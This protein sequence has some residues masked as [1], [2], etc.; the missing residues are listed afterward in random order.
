MQIATIEEQADLVIVIQMRIGQ[1]EVPITFHQMHGNPAL[2]NEDL[3]HDALHCS[4]KFN[5]D[6]VCM[7]ADNFN[8]G[9]DR[10]PFLIPRVRLHAAGESSALMIAAMLCTRRTPTW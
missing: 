1:L 10:E 8:A 7:F 6:G 5:A 4:A 2:A 9:N 3:R